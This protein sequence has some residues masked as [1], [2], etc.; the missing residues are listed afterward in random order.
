MYYFKTA[1]KHDRNK[2]NSAFQ[3]GLTAFRN[4]IITGE[5]RFI[6]MGHVFLQNGKPE[7]KMA[8]QAHVYAEKLN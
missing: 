3:N 2:M 8:R 1:R 4:S 7:E 5:G 6:F